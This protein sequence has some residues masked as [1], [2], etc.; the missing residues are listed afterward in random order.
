MK[1]HRLLLPLILGATAVVAP[2]SAT[3]VVSKPT[4]AQA[5]AA[6]LLMGTLTVGKFE[7]SAPVAS[8]A[9]ALPKDAH[10]H[11]AALLSGLP[12]RIAVTMKTARAHVRAD[13]QAHAAARL[14][15]RR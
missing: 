9:L 10:A 8:A 11:A 15:P 6:A 3:S 7:Q 12:S 13:A 1:P 14:S 4:D 2:A 5:Q